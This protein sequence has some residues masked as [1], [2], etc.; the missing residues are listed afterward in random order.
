MYSPPLTAQFL[1][2]VTFRVNHGEV[3]GVMGSAGSGKSTLLNVIA[4]RIA[5]NI[6]GEI[7]LNGQP[8]TSKFGNQHIIP[9]EIDERF[10]SL[11][12]S[13]NFGVHLL[14]F[15][16]VE[17]TVRFHSQ[18]S[19]NCNAEAIAHRGSTLMQ[20]FDLTLHSQRLVS[21][22]TESARRRLILVLHLIKDPVLI[23]V[24][25]ALLDLDALISLA[26]VDRETPESYAETQ[27]KAANLVDVFK[28]R[29]SALDLSAYVQ[30]LPSDTPVLSCY[31]GAPTHSR[32]FWV[33]VRIVYP[34]FTAQ[35][36][37]TLVLSVSCT[38][39]CYKLLVLA[40]YTLIADCHRVL[41]I[42]ILFASMSS[43]IAGGFLKSYQSFTSTNEILTYAA[44]LS[45]DRFAN[46]ILFHEFLNQTRIPSCRRNEQQAFAKTDDFCRWQS[47]AEYLAEV[48]SEPLRP[49][50]QWQGI[51]IVALGFLEA[52][53]SNVR[54]FNVLVKSLDRVRERY[55]ETGDYTYANDQ[56]KSIRQD[57]I[58]QDIRNEFA[59]SV[60]EEHVLLAI[61]HKD[62]EEFN[63]SQQQLKVLYQ[64][65][66][67]SP[68]R[69]QF[70][71][72]RLL[73]YVYVESES[74]ATELLFKFKDEIRYGKDLEMA[75]TVYLAYT[76][77]DR[78]TILKLYTNSMGVFREVMNFFIERERDRYFNCILAAYRPN[79]TGEALRRLLKLDDEELH[80]YLKRFNMALDDKEILE[81]KRSAVAA[82]PSAPPKDSTP[83]LK[84]P[85]PSEPA[86]ALKNVTNSLVTN[87][88]SSPVF[89]F[90]TTTKE[91]TSIPQ[92]PKEPTRKVPITLPSV[93][94]PTKPKVDVPVLQVLPAVAIVTPIVETPKIPKVPKAP[95]ESA[96]AAKK[97]TRTVRRT[98]SIDRFQ[99]AATTFRRREKQEL[100]NNVTGFCVDDFVC[101]RPYA[102]KWIK[103]LRWK[104]F[105]SRL[106]AMNGM[107]RR[108][109]T[110]LVN[111][112][113]KM[114]RSEETEDCIAYMK[115][116]RIQRLMRTY[117]DRWKRLAA[118]KPLTRRRNQE[119]MDSIV[120]NLPIYNPVDLSN[121]KLPGS[122]K[123]KPLKTLNTGNI[124]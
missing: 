38:Y 3:H 122:K 46:L 55:R 26:T 78:Y 51:F 60:Y 30:Q 101:V 84:R 17:Q 83:K 121:F 66:T 108:S 87:I 52:K 117:F 39:L 53:A 89:A 107:K 2:E 48:L 86:K 67:S 100:Y 120:V 33:L 27:S 25:D 81:I 77:G 97:V 68:N 10:T 105:V 14:E 79:I 92:L 65:L 20:Q 124:I 31:F 1:N 118:T 15:L 50:E 110:I 99:T 11:C 93:F 32:R 119:E 19:L 72:Y 34:A 71:A 114:R 94:Q 4:G 102:E 49:I 95:I 54:P 44:T 98:S 59:I 57:L 56:L 123:F 8:L 88:T 63:Q 28:K 104:Q 36:L 58:T 9:I 47:G 82:K 35:N 91:A 74:D 106:P 96:K 37:V 76:S 6:S 5:G 29:R 109:T 61:Q 69:L 7:G 115:R 73:Y 45:T 42:A 18:L 62:R 75:R 23:L 40:L 80:E 116:K 112:T 43:T 41:I 113:A 24:D 64:K 111:P 22:L 21:D 13:V 12:G 70:T 90:S 103:A 16:T 85:R